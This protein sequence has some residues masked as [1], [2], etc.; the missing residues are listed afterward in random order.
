MCDNTWKGWNEVDTWR[1]FHQWETIAVKENNELTSGVFHSEVAQ[2][3]QAFVD[4]VP[5]TTFISYEL[6]SLLFAHIL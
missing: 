4:D 6:D 5:F 3:L 2:K 1:K